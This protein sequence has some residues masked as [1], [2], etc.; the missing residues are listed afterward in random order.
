M[1]TGHLDLTP[2]FGVIFTAFF[3][4]LNLIVTKRV[5]RGFVV[6][7]PTPKYPICRKKWLK[8]RR[9][10]LGLDSPL[11]TRNKVRRSYPCAWSPSRELSA[12]PPMS[13]MLNLQPFKCV[14]C[15]HIMSGYSSTET[16]RLF[17]KSAAGN[18]FVLRRGRKR[19]LHWTTQ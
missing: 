8:I 10:S 2:P 5:Y 19:R 4:R 17:T 3:N 11:Q 15:N 13:A 7:M 12:W 16:Y 18:G 14:Y 1:S 6:K 9:S